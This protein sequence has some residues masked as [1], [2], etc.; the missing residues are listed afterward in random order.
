MFSVNS[1]FLLQRLKIIKKITYKQ[2]MQKKY[3]K[4]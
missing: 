2:K 3:S 4:Y 1:C